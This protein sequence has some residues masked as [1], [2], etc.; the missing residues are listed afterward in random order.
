M[1]EETRK[2]F[3]NEDAAPVALHGKREAGSQI[4]HPVLVDNN[5]RLLVSTGAAAVTSAS[6][7]KIT[8]AS[9]STSVVSSNTN[10]NRVILVND[11]SEAIY[12]ALGATAVMNEGIRLNANGGS[13]IETEYTGVISAICSS[14]GKNLRY[15]IHDTNI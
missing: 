14:G 7:T 4:V 8:V 12:L 9:A 2:I 15:V 10:R 13:L 5:G 3:S 1:P 11:S 6:N